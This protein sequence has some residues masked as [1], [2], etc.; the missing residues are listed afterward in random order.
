[1]KLSPAVG[2]S[3]LGI[4]AIGS[5]AQSAQAQVKI[6]GGSGTINDAKIFV[7]TDAKGSGDTRTTVYRGT[8]NNVR[9][10]TE[11]GNLPANLIFKPS[12]IPT[13]NNG[14]GTAPVVGTTGSVL[15]GTT[16]KTLT[17]NGRP[18]YFVN[19]PTKLDFA[20]T[21]LPCFQCGT[22]TNEYAGP[23]RPL[24]EKGYIL[25][26][27]SFKTVERTTLG[28]PVQYLKP[29]DSPDGTTIGKPFDNAGEKIPASDFQLKRE[30]LTFSGDVKFDITGG[31]FGDGYVTR[32]QLGDT[33]KPGGSPGDN[34][35]GIYTPGRVYTSSIFVSVV[36]IST[37]QYT[38][39]NNSKPITINIWKNPATSG[40][41]GGTKPNPETTVNSPKGWYFYSQTTYFNVSLNKNVY[42][43]VGSLPKSDKKANDK[44]ADDKKADD[45]KANDKKVDDKKVDDKKVDD[46]K[47]DDDEIK[48]DP[49]KIAYYDP[50]NGKTYVPVGVAS[51]VFPDMI[52]LDEVKLEK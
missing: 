39:V 20:L 51:R 26:P 18:A 22:P 50:T 36:N 35:G 21:A 12:F 15:G 14:V 24:T 10:N 13:F 49:N 52:G 25:T 43:I 29:G 30:G 2:F 5:F 9:I 47:V 41:T 11:V 23:T 16:F 32:Q 34:P 46:K 4:L 38:Y 3:L 48:I 17:N 28:F 8:F 37:T 45:K 44:K 33:L 40:E 42:V 7:P 27:F 6:T 19:V 1:M 31:V